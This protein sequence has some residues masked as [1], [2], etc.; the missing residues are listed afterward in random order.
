MPMHVPSADTLK[1]PRTRQRKSPRISVS[2]P[3]SPSPFFLHVQETRSFLVTP[4]QTVLPK[5]RIVSSPSSAELL[6]VTEAD[7]FSQM[8]HTDLTPET[9][10][11]STTTNSPPEMTP[12]SSVN[13][14]V[15]DIPEEEEPVESELVSLDEIAA[16]VGYAPAS[17]SFTTERRRS[18]ISFAV[19]SKHFS[20]PKLGYTRLGFVVGALALLVV[21][22]ARAFEGLRRAE[23]TKAAVTSRSMDAFQSLQ[24]ATTAETLKNP[25]LARSHFEQASA[26]FAQASQALRRLGLTTRT[27]LA[28]LPPTRETWK[29][30]NHLLEA[31]ESVAEAGEQMSLALQALSDASAGDLT[32]KLDILSL[33]LRETTPLLARATH[34]FEKITLSSVPESWQS[35]VQDAQT[36]LPELTTHIARLEEQLSFVRDLLGAEEKKRYLVVLQNN[37]ELRPTGGFMGSFALVDA[38][39]GNIDAEFAPGG[40]YDVQGM[41]PGTIVAP[42]ALQLINPRFEF[43][44]AN[45]F[46][47]FPTSARQMLEFY[48]QAQG[49]TVDGVLAVNA[50]FVVRLLELLGPVELPRYER[51]FTAENF[52]SEAQLIAE[53]THRDVAEQTGEDIAPKAFIGELAMVLLDRAADA[54][55]QTLFALWQE[56]EQGLG[57]RDLQLYL[58]DQEAE[59]NVL[60]LGWA[61]EMKQPEGDYLMVVHTN[62]G[63]EKT[64]A[65]MDEHQELEVELLPSGDALHTLTVTRAHH[66]IPKRVFYGV[67]NVDYLRVYVPSGSELISATGFVDPGTPI[68][69]VPEPGWTVDPDIQFEEEQAR[70]HGASNTVVTDA[71]GKT[72]FGNW[73]K[74]PPGG[75]STAEIVYRVPKIWPG[76][77]ETSSRTGRA[78]SAPYQF[79]LQQQP[80][81]ERRLFELTVTADGDIM[82][83]SNASPTR[84][85]QHTDATDLSYQTIFHL[86]E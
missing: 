79:Y 21:F 47:D 60:R 28:L 6:Q 44:D 32:V 82:A 72:V 67:E 77:E 63:G 64:D 70:V 20:F 10:S 19:L 48:R 80:G 58:T 37:S 27:I 50:S 62:L 26:Q 25:D 42:A 68:S 74:T 22:P 14:P 51:T 4:E 49:P 23:E 24:Q 41:L 75:V 55:P 15:L 29:T 12:P 59:R 13:W 66:G 65:V 43:Q 30:A 2:Q 17:P 73:M 46:P 9:P 8:K 61:G 11:L 71:F 40:T 85:V 78:A 3:I 69:G 39:R 1:K 38:D 45:W 84:H 31:G 53:L 56:I 16:S 54:D 76:Q 34:A 36:A 35:T 7:L 52:F 5:P 83:A 33:Y 57:Q 81:V 86:A 18:P